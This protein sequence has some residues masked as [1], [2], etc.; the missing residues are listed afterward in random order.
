MNFNYTILFLISFVCFF[1]TASFAQEQLVPMAIN[2][3]IRSGSSKVISS[4]KGSQA[5]L[6]LPFLDDF[7]DARLFPD[8]KFWS[9]KNV[10][11]NNSYAVNPKTIGVATFDAVDSVGRV[12]SYASSNAAI[13]DYLTSNS[14]RLDSVFSPTAKKLSPSDSIYLSFFVQPAGVGNAPDIGDSIV[15]QFYNS[16]A[17]TWQSVWKHGGL[18]L[19]TFQNKYGTQMAQ[20][21]IPIVNLE[22][23]NSD[24]RFRFLNYA[25]ILNNTIPSWRSGLYD[26]W[27]LDYVYLNRNRSFSDSTINDVALASNVTSLLKNYQAMP[28][29]Q[30]KV[31]PSAEMDYTKSIKTV[32]LDKSANQK[33]V[34]RFFSVY[35]KSDDSLWKANPYPNAINMGPLSVN[36]FAPSYNDLI[37]YSAN[38]N[39]ADFLVAYTVDNSSPPLDITHE[40][41]TLMFWQRFYN[42]YAYDDGIP[43]AGYGL[44]SA[45]AKFAYKFKLNK[46][47]S[48]QSIQMYFNQT[49]GLANQQYFDM[50]IWSDNAG[51]PGAELYRKTGRRPEFEDELFKFHTYVLDDAIYISGTF[52]IGFEQI[53]KD[54]L[55]IGFDINNDNKSNIFYNTNGTWQ[56]SSYT[57]SVMIRPVFGLEDLAHVGIEKV[58]ESSQFQIFPNPNNS[59]ILNF[60]LTNEL[61]IKNCKIEIYASNGEQLINTDFSEAI[62]IENLSTGLYLVRLINTENGI[63]TTQKLIVNK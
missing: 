16:V 5:P 59:S 33:N 35:S 50:I 15:L 37:F 27:N 19:D 63:A 17:N 6:V 49:I 26:F 44:S 30:F 10:F 2:P 8:D 1:D 34:N 45:H 28:W 54:N 52:Y 42:Y 43:E 11:I 57:G 38:T 12:Y 56:N 36:V 25:S 23:Y 14:I 20:F 60:K 58:V 32:N 40:N 46:P 7:S 29:N 31:S 41:D 18:S 55:N 39:Y 62:S 9:D 53:T 51:Q 4:Q 24:F 61:E 21:M 13:M 47:D 22:Y 48:L 3:T